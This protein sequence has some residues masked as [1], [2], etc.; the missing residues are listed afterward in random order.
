MTYTTVTIGRLTLQ[1]SFTIAANISAGT[2]RRTLTLT[3]EESYPPLTTIAEVQRRNEDILGLNNRLVPIRFGTKSD[4]DGWYEISDV[5]TAPRNYQGSEL[6]AFTWSIQAERIGPE[7]AVDLE[8]R[9]TGIARINDHGLTGERWHAPAGGAYAYYTGTSQ[10]SGAVSRS[11]SDGVAVNA[12]RSVPASTNPRWAVSLANSGNG[13]ARVKVAGT[14]RVAT[15]ISVG[16]SAWVLENGLVSASM[17]GPAASATLNVANYDGASW[18][19][20]A[21]N[22]TLGASSGVGVTSFDAATVLRNDYE[23]CTVRLVKDRNPGRTLLDLTLRRGS[24]F[25]EGYLQTDSSTLLSVYLKTAQTSTATAS[26]GYVVATS[27]DAQ[28]N[29]VIVGSARSFTGMTTQGG[30]NKAAAVKLDFYIGAVVGGSAAAAGDAASV[31]NSHY[32]TSMSEV[33]L[34]S[35][36]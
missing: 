24:R 12:W 4:H 9:I 22:I 14:E 19:S 17:A 21:W 25:V 18:D 7:N 27:N 23:V 30:L 26:T 5:N 6:V 32:L 3:G 13:R 1:E 10:P 29:K 28:G 15:N 2:D 36:R 16:A 20:T 11:T 33:T 34:G 8:S 35:V 31:L